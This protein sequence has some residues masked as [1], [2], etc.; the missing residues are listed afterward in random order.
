MNGFGKGLGKGLPH[1]SKNIY[2]I[3]VCPF[4]IVASN[5]DVLKGIS[6][7]NKGFISIIMVVSS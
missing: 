5:E 7:L 1:F 3:P 6:I 2:C 4:K